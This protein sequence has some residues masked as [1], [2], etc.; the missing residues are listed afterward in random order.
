MRTRDNVV[1]G[2]ILTFAHSWSITGGVGA[3]ECQQ[4]TA[5]H[6]DMCSTYASTRWNWF[7]HPKATVK[8]W[9][10]LTSR[11]AT[12]E[13]Y[14]NHLLTAVS[15]AECRKIMSPEAYHKQCLYDICSSGTH[16]VVTSC[17]AMA[18]YAQECHRYLNDSSMDVLDGWT[19]EV[20]TADI[21]S[22][23]NIT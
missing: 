18:A 1:E 16:N 8:E 13:A 4:M 10:C 17:S 2:D 22:C 5:I 12:A 21:A 23:G 14:C 20:E 15:F 6:S 19:T 3:A 9:K 11:K 7:N